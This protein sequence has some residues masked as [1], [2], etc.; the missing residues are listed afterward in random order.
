MY[1]SLLEFRTGD[2]DLQNMHLPATKHICTHCL[3]KVLGHNGMKNHAGYPDNEKE[4]TKHAGEINLRLYDA[5]TDWELLASCFQTGIFSHYC[6]LLI[7]PVLVVF[8]HFWLGIPCG[9][10]VKS[11]DIT[12]LNHSIISPLCLLWV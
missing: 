3:E 6:T 5:N 8:S 7:S 2:K 4:C 12:A 9:P 10:V 1:T 11:A